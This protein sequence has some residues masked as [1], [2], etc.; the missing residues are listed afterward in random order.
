M[1]NLN[2]N[3]F[4]KHY[5]DFTFNHQT[6]NIPVSSEYTVNYETFKIHNNELSEIWKT[7]PV[8]CRWGF[9]NSISAN[10]VPYMLNNSIVFEDY[11]RTANTHDPHPKRIERNLDYFYT[12]NSSTFSATSRSWSN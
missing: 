3:T 6:V 10:D 12:I 11:N 4:P 7:N 9:Q 1:T 5:D 2:S 8:Y